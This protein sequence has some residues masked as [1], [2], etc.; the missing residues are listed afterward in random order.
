MARPGVEVGLR[1][2]LRPLVF[3]ANEEPDGRPEGNAVLN[4]RLQLD[5][6]LLVSLHEEQDPCQI[7]DGTV[8]I[9]YALG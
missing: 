1:V 7:R 5:E 3:V 4:P 2:V 8:H 9:A 6:V